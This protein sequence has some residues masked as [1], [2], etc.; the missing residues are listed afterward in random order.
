MTLRTPSGQLAC[1]PDH[2]P[3]DTFRSVGLTTTLRTPSGHF[4]VSWPVGLTTTLRTPSGQLAC[5]PDHKPQDTFRCLTVSRVSDALTH[6]LQVL[7][8]ESCQPQPTTG[9]P[10]PG[11]Q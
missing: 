11:L 7:N 5:W 4:Q 9:A 6:L 8:S 1:W 10:S 3:Q 2:N